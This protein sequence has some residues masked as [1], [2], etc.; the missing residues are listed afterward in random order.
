MADVK[1][2]MADRLK[3]PQEQK[4]WTKEELVLRS[5]EWR[6]GQVEPHE[7]LRRVVAELNEVSCSLLTL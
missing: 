5:W 4:V 2:R 1:N 7:S 3:V 6:G